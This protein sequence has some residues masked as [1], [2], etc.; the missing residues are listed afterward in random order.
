MD[1][2]VQTQGLKNPECTHCLYKPIY[3]SIYLS[4]YVYPLPC[5]SLSRINRTPEQTL[6]AT[7]N[8]RN[9][10]TAAVA[11]L[12]DHDNKKHIAKA[13]AASVASALIDADV[14]VR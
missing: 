12:L 7:I 5:Y 13:A 4:I 8:A 14:Q 9:G 10:R 1:N 11:V 2:A 6:A 3:L